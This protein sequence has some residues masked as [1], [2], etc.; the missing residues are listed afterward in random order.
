[1]SHRASPSRALPI[2]VAFLLNVVAGPLAPVTQLASAPVMALSGSS[3]NALDGN[4]VDDGA[5]ETDWCTP[6]PN[7]ASGIDSPSGS[8]D[9]SFASNNNKEDSNVPTLSQGT[10][11]NNKD[12]LLREYVASETIC[13]DLFVYLAW[14]RADSTGTS[15]ID[16]E[17]N[18]SDQVSSNGVTK[19]RTEGDLLVTFDFQA[20]PGSQGGYEV[21]LT[22]RTWDNDAVDNPDPTSSP[23]NTGRWVNPVNLVTSGLAEGSVND[24]TVSDCVA[25]PNVDLPEATFGEAILNLSDILGGDC[26]AFGSIFTKSRSSNS[27]SADLKDRI[28]PLPVD[29]STCGQLTILKDDEN[30]DPLGGATFSITPNPFTGSGSL[31]VTDDAGAD[32]DAADGVIHLSGVEPDDYEVCETGAPDGYIIDTDCQTLTVAQ[33]G[34][35]QFGPFV[36]GLGDISWVKRDEQTNAKIGGATFTLE[37]IGGAADG[38]GPITVVDSGTNDEDPDAGELLVTGL[39][40][41]TYLITETVAPDGYDLPADP[42]QEVVLNGETAS[43]ANPFLDPPQA[44]AS[45]TK[46]AVLSPIVAGETASFDIV[47]SAGGTGRSEDVTLTDLNETDHTWTVS[48]PDSGDCAD[49]SIAPG[50]TLSCDFGDIANGG[51]REITISM[52]SDEADCELGIANTATVSSSNDHDGSNNEDSASIS[53]LCPNPGVVK[54]AVVTPIVFGDD[55]VFTVTVT[56]GGSGPATNVVLSDLN[57]T[58][59]DWTVSGANAAA[60]ADL[61]VAD[62][63][64]LTCTWAQIPAGESR[65]ITITLTS[66]ESDCEL[67]IENT[68]SI[69]ADA[70]VDESN[71]SDSAHIAVLCPNPGVTKDAVLSPIDAGDDASFTIVVSASGTGDSENVVLTDTNGTSH[72]WTISGANAGACADLSVDP[73]EDL[74]CDFGTIPNGQSRTVT[75]TM[76]SD[77]DDCANGIENTAS[78]EADA[79]TDESNNSDSA[80]IEVDCPDI[81]VDKTGSGTVN[82][83]DAIFF[84]ITVTNAGDGDAYDFAFNDTLPDVQNGWTLA[85]FDNPPASCALNGLA[86][87]CS[88]ADGMFGAGDS[89]TVRVEATSAPADCGDLPNSAS[90]SASNEADEDLGNNSDDHT[91][92][93]QCPDLSAAKDADDDVV[94]AGEPIGFTITI[95]NSGAAG[96]GSAYDVQ[97]ADLLPAGSDLD[98]SEDPDSADCQITGSVGAETLECSFGDLAPGDS[99]SVHVVS[100]TTQLDC[101]TFPNVASLTSDNHP[102]LNPSA[103]TT[104][105]CAGLNISKLADN[106]TIVAGDIASYTVVVWNALEPG[107]TAL[108]ASWSDELPHGVSWSI[109]LLNPDGDDTCASSIDSDGNQSA[110]CQFGDLAPSSMADG[111]VIEISGRTDREDC[112]QLDNTAFA[113]ADNADTVQASASI[114]VSCPTVAIVKVN[115]QPDPVLPGT[116]VSYTLTVT[117]SDSQASD[118]VV[119]DSLPSGLD[120]PT[121]ISDGGTYDA[122]TGTISWELGDLDPGSYPLTYQAAVS[123]DAEHGDELVNLAV[124]TSPDSQ[125]P[126]VQNLADECDDD[127][128]VTVRVPTLVIDKSADT[129]VVHFVFDADGNVLSVDP[130]QVT[131]TLTYT[132]ANGPVTDAVITDPLPDFLVFVSASDGGVY[133]PATGIISWELGDLTVDGSDRV[134][135]VTTV[136]PDAPE[137]DPILNVATIDSNETQPDDGEDS[138]TVTS[139]SELG[140]NPTPKPSVPNTALVFGPAGEPVSIPLE[141]LGLVFIGSLGALA[142]ANVRATRRR[143]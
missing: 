66:G 111:K 80:S 77:A 6:A 69:E 137:T 63:E 88:V 32:D 19:V 21:V 96:T 27:F 16:F 45:I 87:S 28:N 139:E 79:D 114:H 115:D 9:T 25:N 105:E 138:I 24:G 73:G 89:F 141:L 33:N 48:G 58:G 104:V 84:E 64:T 10:I 130:E 15:T 61:T 131:W 102:E 59:H 55:A 134:S 125:C 31:S 29:L 94:S 37:G 133:D 71:N 53:V 113:F 116:V 30:G 39:L 56:A 26:E 68:A 35:A 52:T 22:L 36:N 143:R 82:A 40:L 2:I 11:P 5:D 85:S 101:A 13:E 46:D 12:D 126:D 34:S 110:S 100:D 120:A 132:L 123:L 98:W 127:S 4:L 118:V 140:G 18:Q 49:L 78:I 3:F 97:L 41:G 107:G 50:E 42:D 124:V 136:D 8:N 128:I 54:D 83:T 142:F 7:L 20:N 70:D 109:E 65:S 23:A 51:S 47:V 129:E 122:N 81:V 121:S 93:V 99:V 14:I 91:I 44:D 67:G 108:N 38:F 75:I 95:S 86:L 43:A 103:D 92:V 112:G 135:F 74:S 62:G 57:D 119:T 76:E 60:C 117:V 1:M 106:G 72:A 90:A 17:F